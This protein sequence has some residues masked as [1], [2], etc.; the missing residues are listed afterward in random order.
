MKQDEN[1]VNISSAGF[2]PTQGKLV[3]LMDIE[4]KD[5]TVKHGVPA[6]TGKS[7]SSDD[8]VIA[9]SPEQIRRQVA[10]PILCK[11]RLRPD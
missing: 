8:T 2:M 9:L 1:I 4:Y 11:V 3:P 7:G 10:Q 6:T 5:G